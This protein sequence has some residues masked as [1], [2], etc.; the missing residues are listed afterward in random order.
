MKICV[1]Q[2]RSVKGDIQQ[3]IVNHKKMI[4]LAVSAGAGIIVFPELSLTGYE[5]QLAK[6]IAVTDDDMR[7]NDFQKISDESRIIIGVG[8]PIK[9]ENGICIS[10]IIFQPGKPRH[11]YS[12]KYLHP[13]EEEFF[14]SGQNFA[15]LNLNEINLAFAICYEISVP[16]HSENAFNH[17]AQIYIAS[18][19]KSESGVEQAAKTLSAIARNYS[20]TVLFSNS[21]GYCDNFESA[22]RSSIWNDKGLLM[23]ALDGSHQGL[24]IIDSST[25]EVTHFDL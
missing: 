2:T 24:L 15:S 17:A 16:E 8:M 7:L 23:A 19:A 5:P 25:H 12:K 13:D 21:I 10:M 20:M 6:E 1:A 4:T 3:N 11:V 18:A 9:K 22:G 14:V